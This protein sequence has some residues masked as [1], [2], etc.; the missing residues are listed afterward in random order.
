MFFF[1]VLN[2]AYGLRIE[3]GRGKKKL[4][5]NMFIN[6]INLNHIFVFLFLEIAIISSPNIF[7][8]LICPNITR[9][10]EMLSM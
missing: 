7:Y 4:F 10:R 3:K 2:D 1:L 5:V 9:I 6:I 8:F